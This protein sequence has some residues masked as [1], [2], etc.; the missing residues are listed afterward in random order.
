MAHTPSARKRI[1][2]NEKRRV[3]NRGYK[4]RMKKRIAL[5]V[6]ASPDKKIANLS[7][8][9]SAIDRA[10]KKRIIHKNT[11]ARKKSKLATKMSLS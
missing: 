3:R 2:E 10:A 4:R 7:E 6:S 11:A 9:Y 1:R 8:A 5:A